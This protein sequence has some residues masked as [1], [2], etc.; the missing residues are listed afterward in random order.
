MFETVDSQKAVKSVQRVSS[1]L[2]PYFFHLHDF[3]EKLGNKECSKRDTW[4][5]LGK[6]NR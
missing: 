1:T 2:S 3:A 5:A 4:I 6:E